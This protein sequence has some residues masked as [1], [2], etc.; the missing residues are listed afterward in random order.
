YS[1]SVSMVMEDNSKN[2]EY[3]IVKL[4]GLS[5][6]VTSDMESFFGKLE[7]K[8]TRHRQDCANY[9]LLAVDEFKKNINKYKVNNTNVDDVFLDSIISQYDSIATHISLYDM[10]H[11]DT[12]S[13]IK[14]E[15]DEF[16]KITKLLE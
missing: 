15:N 7:S 12:D 9:V 2:K 1:C 10:L 5:N 6:R 8:N 14:D 4:I 11:P 13:H 16:I 3:Q